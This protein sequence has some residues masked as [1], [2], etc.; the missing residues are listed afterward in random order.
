MAY[1]YYAS[2]ALSWA[3]ADTREEAI[4]RV[5]RD[6]GADIIR[7]NVKAH[8]GL[9]AESC[10]VELPIAAP[11]E[12]RMYMPDGVQVSEHETHRITNARGAYKP[13]EQS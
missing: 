4:K 3:V 2:T 13:A 1:H 8:G 7:A 6:A 10:R 12:I 9:Y 5:A 11:Y